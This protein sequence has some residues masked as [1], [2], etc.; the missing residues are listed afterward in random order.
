[1]PSSSHTVKSNHRSKRSTP[2]FVCEI[3]L[4]VTAAQERTLLVR[5]A[6]ARQLYNALLGEGLRRLR[7]LQQSRAYQAARHMPVNAREEKKREQQRRQRAMA[8]AKARRA[9]GFTEYALS[10]YATTLHHSWIGDHVDAVI[11]QTLT[12]RAFQAVNRMALG[13]AKQVRFKGRR[14][15]H[16]IGSLEGKS[17]QAGLRWRDD[18]LHWGSLA[19]PM[20]NKADRDPVIAYGL[21]QR[22]KYVRLVRRTIRGRV[23][24]YAQLVCEGLPLRKLNPKTGRFQHPYGTEIQGLDIGPSTIAIVGETQAEL[25]QFAAEI[26]RDHAEIRRLQRH[27]DRQR[28]AN[29]PE[30]YDAQKR[31]IKGKHP[32]QKSRR[33]MQTETRLAELFRREA[34][35]RKTL[36][37]QFANE[38]IAHGTTIKT[39]KLSY[40]AFQKRFGRSISV[41]APKLFL[42][43]LTRKAESAGGQV[44]EFNTRTT[45][46][47]Q[48]CV[49]GRRIPKRLSER[50]HRCICGVVMQRDL[51]SGF[52]A[53]YVEDDALQVAQAAEAWPGAEPLLRTAWQRATSNQP[54][55][56]GLRPASF[57]RYPSG[58]SQSGSSEK[59][60]LP[61]SERSDG[62]PRGR[63]DHRTPV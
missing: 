28:R 38:I 59:E 48:T 22:I 25:Q 19:L 52:L 61:K 2:S 56:R 6:A 24:W 55:S 11:G 60:S 57:G 1:L 43:L 45:A 27:L 26:V 23:R 47:S 39:E 62:V 42:T 30:C 18:V 58:P 20:K 49:C 4:R 10:R 14:G 34:A 46:L 33:Q 36:H 13:L 12:K 29:N 32:T 50:V 16:Q 41:R 31:P 40:T 7:L 63:A 51:F 37:G 21:A 3:P 44:V 53:R 5:F 54:A 35:H 17:N 8:F 9:V 15:I